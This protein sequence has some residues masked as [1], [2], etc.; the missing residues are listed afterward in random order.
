[1]N[2]SNAC[3]QA[4][5]T[6]IKTGI[7]LVGGGAG[8]KVKLAQTPFTPNPDSDPTT[9]TE[10]NFTGYSAATITAMSAN[11]K[12]GNTWEATAG[13]LAAFQPTGTTVGNSIGGYWIEDNT[14]VLL[15]YDTFSPPIAMQ[16]P[17]DAINLAVRWQVQPASWPNTL[18]P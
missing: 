6:A 14:G 4:I 16:S 15:G 2:Q 9:F 12:T 10:A 7:L 11:Q 18:L 3:L 17:S 1:M 5:L 8:F 13:A